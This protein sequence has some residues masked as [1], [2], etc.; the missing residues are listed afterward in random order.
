LSEDYHLLLGNRYANLI[1][2]QQGEDAA[3]FPEPDDGHESAYEDVQQHQYADD[4]EFPL[5]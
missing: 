3:S 1:E 2:K 4:D 5:A